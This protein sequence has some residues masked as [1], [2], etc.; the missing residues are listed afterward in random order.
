MSASLTP[1]QAP[2]NARRTSSRLQKQ[3]S[4]YQQHYSPQ[5]ATPRSNGQTAHSKS[6]SNSRSTQ[7]LDVPSAPTPSALSTELLQL[8]LLHSHAAPTLAAWSK[9]AKM[10][11]QSRFNGLGSRS[12]ELHAIGS[13]QHGLVNALALSEWGAGIPS[14]TIGEKVETLSRG[15][16]ELEE[17]IRDGGKFERIRSLWEVWFRE[18]EEV[19]NK[20]VSGTTRRGTDLLEG[21]GDGW[22]AEALVLERELGYMKRDLQ[23]FGD[24]REGSGLGR[25]LGLGRRLCQGLLDEL[26]VMQWIENEITKEESAWAEEMVGRL[27]KGV[28][29]GMIL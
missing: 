2:G 16:R 11:F 26:D 28:I 18:G 14:S 3:F 21:I 1:H 19:Q 4:T 7:D 17:S 20:R 22:K 8:H 6:S 23:A 13:E 27:E 9:S 12:A 24:V 25:L 5:K 15:L 10:H 29:D